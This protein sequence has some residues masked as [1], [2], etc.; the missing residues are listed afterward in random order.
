VTVPTHI[1]TFEPDL[2]ALEAAI[3]PKT[4]AVIVNSPNNPT[5]VIYKEDAIKGIADLMT[6]KSEEYNHCIYIISDDP[7]REIVYSDIKIPFMLNY[8]KNT[9][10]VYSYSKSLSLPGERIGY[11]AFSKD[12]D[13]ADEVT[14]CLGIAT[15]TVGYTNAPSLFQRVIAKC[16]DESVDVK[17]YKKNRDLLYNH[18]ISLGFECAKPEGAFYLF[19][20]ALIPNDKAFAVAAKKYNLIIVPGSAFGCPG[21]FRLAYCISYEKIYRSL[22]AWTRLAKEFSYGEEKK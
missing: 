18:L 21:Y 3:T 14:Q 13:E 16:L 5:G 7:Y 2:D 20:K 6:K 10:I 15:R 19:P 17:I 12:M 11:V 4:K 1:G 8:Y 22:D 9:F